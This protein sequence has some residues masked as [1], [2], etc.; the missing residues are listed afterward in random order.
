MNCE[1]ASV[2]YIYKASY[3]T[4]NNLKMIYK[5]TEL[6]AADRFP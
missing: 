4:S 2:N 3:M 1:W 5:S 6:L